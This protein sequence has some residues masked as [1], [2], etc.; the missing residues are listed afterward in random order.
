[1]AL[2]ETVYTAFIVLFLR[3]M[4]CETIVTFPKG[5]RL[6]FFGCPPFLS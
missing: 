3:F 2:I 4:Y 6:I 1:M 5:S